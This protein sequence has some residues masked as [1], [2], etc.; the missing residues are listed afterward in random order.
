MKT[1]LNK[2]TLT[3]QCSVSGRSWGEGEEWPP[4]DIVRI[5]VFARMAI[6]TFVTSQFLC[7][8]AISNEYTYKERLPIAALHGHVQ[9]KRRETKEDLDRQCQESPDGEKHRFDQDWRGDQKQR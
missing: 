8:I 9:G 3:S 5:S 7:V 1:A 2:N 6:F 4:A